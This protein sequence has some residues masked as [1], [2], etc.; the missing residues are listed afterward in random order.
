MSMISIALQVRCHEKRRGS[1]NSPMKRNLSVSST[2][3]LVLFLCMVMPARA[4]VQVSGGHTL[5]G[6]KLF[7]QR[8]TI[9]H[10]N[11]NSAQRAP[12]R[13]TLMKL[14]PEAVLA[15]L[16][17]GPMRAQAADLT[18]VQKGLIAEFLGGRRLGSADAGSA[19][20]MPNRCTTNPPLSD[21]S[22][23][24]EWKWLGG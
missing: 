2:V 16:T 12:D 7:E 3:G 11:A 13:E 4:Q 23:R 24:P 6:Q 1:R 18:D 22:A 9:C 20:A 8:C 5:N 14:T 15:A 10:G 17:T 19:K 21:P